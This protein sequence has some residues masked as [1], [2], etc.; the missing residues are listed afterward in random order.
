VEEYSRFNKMFLSGLKVN[1]NC[2]RKIL[3]ISITDHVLETADITR[4]IFQ[5]SGVKEKR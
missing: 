1:T 4:S 2:S 5:G 3:I